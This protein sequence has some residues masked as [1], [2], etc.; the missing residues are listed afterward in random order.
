MEVASIT[1]SLGDAQLANLP[2]VQ[3]I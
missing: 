1:I 2:I 3:E